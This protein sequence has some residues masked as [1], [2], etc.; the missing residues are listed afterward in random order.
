M[1]GARR[2]DG[3]LERDVKVLIEQIQVEALRKRHTP[4]P[5]CPSIAALADFAKGPD[6]Y[7]ATLEELAHILQCSYCICTIMMAQKVL[8]E[9]EPEWVRSAPSEEE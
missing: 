7:Q 5:D 4:T 3:L 9:E 2:R 1:L 6:A 8:A